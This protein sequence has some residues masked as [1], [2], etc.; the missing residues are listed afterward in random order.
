MLFE[1][2]EINPDSVPINFLLP[3]K[4][5]RLATRDIS[6]LTPEY[7]IKVLCLARLMLPKSDIRCAAGR[8]VY[9]KGHEKTLFKVADS[10]FASGYLT[11]GGQSLEE[12]FRTIEAAGFTWQVESA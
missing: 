3:V 9:F 11:E 4:G 1:L 6:A 8:E 12:T 2:L 7:C 10:I 5:T